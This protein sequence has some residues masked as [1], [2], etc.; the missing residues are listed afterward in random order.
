[1]KKIFFLALLGSLL[2]SLPVHAE[3]KMS[4]E[5]REKNSPGSR[6]AGKETTRRRLLQ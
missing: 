3:A 1:M 6:L 5:T 4:E 2:S